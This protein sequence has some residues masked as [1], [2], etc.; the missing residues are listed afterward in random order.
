MT[1]NE[2]LLDA[3]K[4]RDIAIVRYLLAQN[5]IDVNTKDSCGIAP[6]HN[7]ARLGNLEVV[8]LLLQR[9]DIN[10]NAKNDH[11]NTPLHEAVRYGNSEIVQLLL[12]NGADVNA[13]DHYYSTSLHEAVRYEK[14]KVVR[15][16]LQQKDIDV[17]AKDN[18]DNTPLHE[19]AESQNTKVVLTLLENS[20]NVN[21]KNIKKETPISIY[22]TSYLTSYL[23]PHKSPEIFF[24]LLVYDATLSKDDRKKIN[25]NSSLKK[26]L[27]AFEAIK[28]NLHLSRLIEIYRNGDKTESAKAISQYINNE[29]DRKELIAEFKKVKKRC[30]SHKE[31]SFIHKYF[32]S[33]IKGIILKTYH[34]DILRNFL[35]NAKLQGA[36]D[37]SKNIEQH[38]TDDERLNL[39]L[40]SNT[41]VYRLLTVLE[42][43][44][45]EPNTRLT[46]L[47]NLIPCIHVIAN[48]D[49]LILD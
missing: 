20:A 47:K 6:L 28:K 43:Y 8:Q 42:D 15:L 3:S 45:R 24:L 26:C 2:E 22:L 48:Q 35:C 18:N 9:K 41:E 40:E 25:H 7:A 36:S 49:K 10:V 34:E 46:V 32:I 29:T 30:S 13:R 4:N 19:A 11:D 33:I 27:T 39:V 16:L 23:T 37:I 21:A 17:N 14:T 38:L 44:K 31:L 12:E 1:P 5:E